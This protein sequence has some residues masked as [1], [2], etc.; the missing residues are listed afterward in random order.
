MKEPEF[1]PTSFERQLY[2]SQGK[3]APRR[4]LRKATTRWWSRLSRP[5]K[6]II[7]IAIIYLLSV[8]V[9]AIRGAIRSSFIGF[10]IYV[11]IT[12]FVFLA[13]IIAFISI[14]RKYGMYF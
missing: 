3:Q 4:T 8:V 2:M 14:K 13:G 6:I 12:F 5:W 1:N 7:I 11:G 9:M 10:Y